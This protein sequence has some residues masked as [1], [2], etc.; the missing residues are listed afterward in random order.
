M[1]CPLPAIKPA[2]AIISDN[3]HYN[4]FNPAGHLTEFD[5]AEGEGHSLNILAYYGYFLE[6]GNTNRISNSYFLFTL[7]YL[8]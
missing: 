2:I 1:S 3:M 4:A 8:R 7:H 6:L 5:G